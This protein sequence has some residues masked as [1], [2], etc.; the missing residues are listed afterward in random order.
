MGEVFQSVVRKMKAFSLKRLQGSVQFPADI[1]LSWKR[2]LI[3]WH[4]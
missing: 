1:S 3:T 4:S 2:M